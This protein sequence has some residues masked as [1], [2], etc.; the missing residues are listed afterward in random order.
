MQPG[1]RQ[2]WGKGCRGTRS[3]SPAQV[4]VP[5]PLTGSG[6]TAREPR[7]SPSAGARA[8]R[9]SPDAPRSC[10]AA[11]QQPKRESTAEE[12]SCC[13]TQCWLHSTAPGPAPAA[14]GALGGGGN[15]AGGQE[16]VGA[17]TPLAWELE[18]SLTRV[19]PRAAPV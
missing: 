19:V 3:P 2:G 7:G 18:L 5:Q 17:E 11:R 16:K 12:P 14:P 10:A 6:V 8:A 4:P 15:Q 9:R 13:M 1:H